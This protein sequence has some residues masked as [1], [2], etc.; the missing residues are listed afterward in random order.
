MGYSPTGANR[1]K[2]IIAFLR[3]MS[4]EKMARVPNFVR[5]F[6]LK[7]A[8]NQIHFTFNRLKTR[9]KHTTIVSASERYGEKNP[10]VSLAAY[11]RIKKNITIPTGSKR[12]FNYGNQI[13]HLLR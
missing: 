8:R 10:F 11:R 1:G 3:R 4:T 6:T 7:R 13:L 12:S 5:L 9:A 2:S